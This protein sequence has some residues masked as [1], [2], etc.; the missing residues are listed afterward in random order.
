MAMC[1]KWGMSMVQETKRQTAFL[2][3]S[4]GKDVTGKDTVLVCSGCCNKRS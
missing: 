4:W 3:L 1:S 2:L